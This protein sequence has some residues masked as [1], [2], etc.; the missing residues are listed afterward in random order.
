MKNEGCRMNR[1]HFIGAGG[2]GM[3][4]LALLMTWM[5]AREKCLISGSDRAFD[6]NPD[7]PRRAELIRHGVVIHPQQGGHASGAIA[8]VSTA[9]ESSNP[10]LAGVSGIRHRSEIL[11][12][13]VR[14]LAASGR[15][16]V[17]IAGSSGKTT[18]T[19]MTA[20]ICHR[21]G[22][23]PVVYV[24]GSVRE[25]AP[26]GARRG[27][28]PL[29]VEVDESDG[30]IERFT[31]DI[32][33]VTSASEDHK[34]LPEIEELFRRFVAKSRSMILSEQASYLAAEEAG[35]AVAVARCSPSDKLTGIPGAFNRINEAL[36]V[37]AACGLGIP[38]ET[39]R[40]ALEDFPGVGRR[41]EIILTRDERRVVDDFAH[42]P[43]KIAA[44]LAAVKEWKHPVMAVYQPHG[45][46][47]LRM[48][49]D[50]L[51]GIFSRSLSPQ[52]S[53]VLLPIY[54]AGGTADR[55]ISSSD[56]TNL[57]S[58]PRAFTV[59]SRAEAVALAADFLRGPATVIVMGARDPS[60]SGLARDIGDG[61][62]D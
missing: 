43:E 10:D 14:D 52:D 45:Y 40:R 21:A 48:Q 60:L 62:P 36:A 53:V 6:R 31:P 11:E 15:R 32:A 39:A 20:W 18:T 7:D 35:L 57:I 30:S 38:R 3:M 26:Y 37:E 41:L 22:L 19:A 1:Y 47:P 44:S 24:G 50:A 8:V 46:G 4:P 17:L 13:L 2:S 61:C 58:G 59:G 12:K 5:S 9:I 42:N 56:L 27:N 23:D 16:N 28:G 55:T 54:D 29:I 51:G 25:L 33:V 34:P 49:K